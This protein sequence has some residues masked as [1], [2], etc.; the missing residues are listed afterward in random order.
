MLLH[1]I[2]SSNLQYLA[3]TFL[4]RYPVFKE[5]VTDSAKF[6]SLSVFKDQVYLQMLKT[7]SKLTNE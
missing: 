3:I 6:V 1:T 7:L 5:Q 4:F 2:R